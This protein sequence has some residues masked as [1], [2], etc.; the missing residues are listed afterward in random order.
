MS[1]YCGRT[2]GHGESCCEG[3]PCSHCDPTRG[4]SRIT[5][6]NDHI[7]NMR[8]VSAIAQEEPYVDVSHKATLLD[9]RDT[10]EWKAR[11]AERVEHARKWAER[12][13]Y[14]KTEAYR[15]ERESEERQRV[16]IRLEKFKTYLAK[17]FGVVDPENAEFL[18]RVYELGVSNQYCAYG[19]EWDR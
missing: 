16:A 8:S 10:P 15:L 9:F 17:E 11:E 7:L 19:N 12:E 18:L 5:I 1:D 2:L 3:N 13:A 4:M 14:M 6:S